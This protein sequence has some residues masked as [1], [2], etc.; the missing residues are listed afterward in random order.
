MHLIKYFFSSLRIY[1]ITILMFKLKLRRPKEN[2]FCNK[3][4]H[5]LANFVNAILISINMSEPPFAFYFS[6]FLSD[7]IWLNRIDTLTAPR[8]RLRLK[9]T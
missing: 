2:V 6:S 3:Q 5:L 7:L 9:R 8:T 1:F 4:Y